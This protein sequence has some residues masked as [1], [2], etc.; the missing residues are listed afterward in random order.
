M[1]SCSNSDDNNTNVTPTGPISFKVDG[2]PVT[3]AASTI[4]VTHGDGDNYA[5]MAQDNDANFMYFNF[6]ANDMN[7]NIDTF[8]YDPIGDLDY[9]E[10][11]LD[12]IDTQVEINTTGHLKGTFSGQVYYQDADNNPIVKSVTDGKLDITYTAN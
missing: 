12:G 5:L 6:V 9:Y 10:L 2:I 7:M 1:L 4:F 8:H 3:F 11:G